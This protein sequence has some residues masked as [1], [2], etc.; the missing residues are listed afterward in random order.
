MKS[1]GTSDPIA[2]VTPAARSGRQ[3]AAATATAA[4]TSASAGSSDM[5]P[6]TST[7]STVSA[8]SADTMTAAFVQLTWR[9]SAGKG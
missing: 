2:I 8:P 6:R 7:V 1:A 9:I 5:S 4:A 3:R